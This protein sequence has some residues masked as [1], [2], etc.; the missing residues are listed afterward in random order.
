MDTIRS[1]PEL[2]DLLADFAPVDPVGR[3]KFKAPILE[4][5]ARQ[6]IRDIVVSTTGIAVTSTPYGAIGDGASHPLSNYFATLAAA[7][8]TYPAAVALTDEVDWAAIQ[9]A[10]DTVA[11]AGGGEVRLFAGTYLINRSLTMG[12][13]VTLA[14]LGAGTKLKATLANMNL[15][16]AAN[17]TF[18][19]VDRV[20]MVGNGTGALGVL[21]NTCPGSKVTRC[22]ISGFTGLNVSGYGGG[23]HMYL[24]DDSTIEDNDF[25]GNGVLVGGLSADI[26]INGNGVTLDGTKRVNINNN[27]CLSTA[28][29]TNITVYDC[30]WSSAT[31]NICSG[32]KTQASNNNGYGI[33]FYQTVNPNAGAC[34][35]N[36]I[37]NNL[38]YSV[39]GCAIYIQGQADTAAVGNVGEDWGATQDDTTL[40]VGFIGYSNSPR[41]TITGNDGIN[42]FKSFIVIGGLAGNLEGYTVGD[43]TGTNLNGG[44][45]IYLRGPILR[46]SF[47]NNTLKNCGNGIA[48]PPVDQGLDG[49]SFIGNVVD[50]TTAGYTYVLYGAAR[51]T[52]I[53]NVSYNSNRSGFGL[54]GASP[55]N[56]FI[57]NQAWNGSTF[58]DNT[59]NGFDIAGATDTTLVG[60]FA[61]NTAG[62][63]FKWCFFVGA[64]SVRSKVTNNRATGGRTANYNV[65]AT[66]ANAIEFWGNFDASLADAHILLIRQQLKLSGAPTSM[67]QMLLGDSSVFGSVGTMWGSGASFIAQN[68]AHVQGSDLWHQSNA[69]N[70]SKL[71]RLNLNGNL[72]FYSAPAGTADGNFATF[73]GTAQAALVNT[74]RINLA[75]TQVLATRNTGWSAFTGTASKGGFDTS[76]VTLVQLA[77]V[78][79][80]LVDAGLGHGFIGV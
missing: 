32:A 60:N 75:G 53:G 63:G 55:G 62:V 19:V 22:N 56:I 18:C 13:N 20:F 67:V 23:V 80:A 9:K 76:T 46:S 40:V 8:A 74:G 34:R 52:F 37:E 16:T 27:R 61:G 77:Q 14:G 25:S 78:V 44:Y 33:L 36:R 42:G 39:G 2:L 1:T 31:E 49:C 72:E 15:V 35:R 65:D 41:G 4:R 47:S 3:I 68:A 43:N 59:Y 12:T 57:G 54:N 51:C 17:K 48:T 11:A 66:Y 73:W 64:T 38:V 58:A 29:Q 24:S 5:D 30:A 21:F 71:M 79:K 28:V 69:A 45:G 7:Q 70:A 10:L 50:T 26:Q 6:V